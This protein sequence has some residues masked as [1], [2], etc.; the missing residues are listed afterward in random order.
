[1]DLHRV[2]TDE[3][4]AATE[5]VDRAFRRDPVWHVALETADG[6][7]DLRPFWRLYV[8]GAHRYDTVFAGA[9]AGT[10][11]VWLPPGG[12]ELSPDQEADMHRVAEQL[13]TPARVTALLEL[14]DRF[15][16]HH[17]QGE[18]HAYLSL[19]ATRPDL[20]GHGYGQAHLAAALAHWDAAGVPTYLEST[21]PRND[22]RY[23]RQGYVPI[24]GFEAV[25]DDA[26]VTTMWRAVGG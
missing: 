18:P 17:P 14:W 20:A 12:T 4:D 15:D 7:S 24:G 13:L 26:V 9:D 2:V 3:L 25:L 23:A 21:N 11:S 8:A 19:L 5:T 16:E 6:E 22:Q 10:V 1:M